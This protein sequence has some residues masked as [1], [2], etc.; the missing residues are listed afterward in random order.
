MVCLRCHVTRSTLA[1][2]SHTD[3]HTLKS[4]SACLNRTED[5]V[6]FHVPCLLR[7]YNKCTI[8]N[9]AYTT[10]MTHRLDWL[11]FK[12]VHFKFQL[13]S[14]CVVC[15]MSGV[16][17]SLRCS[18]LCTCVL[19]WAGGLSKLCYQLIFPSI[20]KYR[21][22]KSWLRGQISKKKKRQKEKSSQFLPWGVFCLFE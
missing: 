16:L 3:R 19:R 8:K 1:N 6:V 5:R 7:L 12:S 10:H 15:R 11:V 2:I 20:L 17:Q 21:I 14:Y 9:G 18:R 22:G 4:G 13:S